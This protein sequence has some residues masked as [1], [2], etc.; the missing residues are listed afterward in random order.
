MNLYIVQ[1]SVSISGIL[2]ILIYDV[3]KYWFVKPH[4]SFSQFYVATS[5]SVMEGS[6]SRSLTLCASKINIVNYLLRLLTSF[7]NKC[8]S[9][10]QSGAGSPGVEVLPFRHPS[11]VT[12]KVC[13]THVMP[14]ARVCN[15]YVTLLVGMCHSSGSP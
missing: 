2:T 11:V 14:G 12:A 6:N 13:V 7:D 5:A 8:V 15:S 3:K 4:T 1:S 10:S 9:I